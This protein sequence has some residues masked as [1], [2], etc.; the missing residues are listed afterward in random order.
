MEEI[1]GERITPS[2]YEFSIADWDDGLWNDEVEWMTGLLEGG[3]GMI[4]IWRFSRCRFAR[5]TVGDPG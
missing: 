5:F 3:G 2:V 1:P 4:T